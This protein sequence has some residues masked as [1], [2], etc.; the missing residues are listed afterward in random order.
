MIEIHFL[1]SAAKIQKKLKTLCPKALDDIG[2][3]HTM[4]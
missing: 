4:G 1:L 2:V 3:G